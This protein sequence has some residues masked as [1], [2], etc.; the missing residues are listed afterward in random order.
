MFSVK[1]ICQISFS[2]DNKPH[3]QLNCSTHKSVSLKT[4]A[5]SRREMNRLCGGMRFSR[6]SSTTNA[7]KHTFASVNVKKWID[8]VVIWF[9]S[10][11]RWS[12]RADVFVLVRALRLSALQLWCVLSFLQFN[13]VFPGENKRCKNETAVISG[14]KFREMCLV[15][16]LST[17][18]SFLRA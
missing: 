9:W 10:R 8:F 6:S 17:P 12:C 14:D 3:V 16:P 4:V 7:A 18:D 11:N 2:M 15:L 1:K 5:P 13:L